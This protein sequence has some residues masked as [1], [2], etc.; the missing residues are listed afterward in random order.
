MRQLRRLDLRVNKYLLLAIALSVVISTS[1]VPRTA[2]SQPPATTQTL[3]QINRDSL[4][5]QNHAVEDIL[6]CCPGSFGNEPKDYEWGL[7][8]YVIAY[9]LGFFVGLPLAMLVIVYIANFV[10]RIV[11]L[12]RRAWMS[13]KTFFT[14]T[15]RTKHRRD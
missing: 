9:A 11:G 8:D 3:S 10:Y 4:N 12:A 14:R 6:A 5:S 2:R 7:F 15:M 1:F 13:V